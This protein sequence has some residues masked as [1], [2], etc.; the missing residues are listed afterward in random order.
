MTIQEL[1]DFIKEDSFIIEY[2]NQLKKL[3]SECPAYENE[4]ERFR[5]AFKMTRAF[6]TDISRWDIYKYNPAARATGKKFGSKT[7]KEFRE[8]IRELWI[9]GWLQDENKEMILR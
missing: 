2:A 5:A 6:A 8:M 4:E 7:S 3:V 9:N 1:P